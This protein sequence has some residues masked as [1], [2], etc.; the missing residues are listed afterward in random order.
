[1]SPH[2]LAVQCE[3]L[4]AS[5]LQSSQ[6]PEP[7]QIRRAVLEMIMKYGARYC[8][9]RV[10]Q[11]FG[12]HPDTAVIRMRWA[13]EAVVGAYNDRNVVNWPLA[14]ATSQCIRRAA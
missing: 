14:L 1:M 4:F 12:D 3:A 8:M 7:R 6:R 5:D 10:A 13:R 11:E 2:N 9:A